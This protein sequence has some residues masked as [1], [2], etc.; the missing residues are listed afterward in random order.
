MK[1]EI[2]CG[3]CH[4]HLGF[5]HRNRHAAIIIDHFQMVHPVEY[6]EL[7]SAKRALV[8]LRKKYKFI[9]ESYLT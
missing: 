6:G 3:Y 9:H 8:A 1:K 2:I 5:D 7:A 4:R